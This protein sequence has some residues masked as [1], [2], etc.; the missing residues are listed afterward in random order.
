MPDHTTPSFGHYLLHDPHHRW[1][2]PA[3]VLLSVMVFVLFKMVYPF[4]SFFA[5]SYFYM[6]AAVTHA[7]VD[8]WP[9]G[10]ARF[11]SW[12]HALHHGDQLLISIQY[13]SLTAATW[14]LVCT[15]LYLF[16]P[17]TTVKYILLAW[18]SCNPLYLYLSNIVASD[19]IFTALSILWFTLLL[20]VAFRPAWYQI[21]LQAVVLAAA[22]TLRYNA[23]YYPLLAIPLLWRSRV[24]WGLR[25]AG[26]LLTVLLIG[27]YVQHTRMKNEAVTGVKAF[28][29]FSSWQTTNNAL[30]MYPYIYVD[31]GSFKDTT[32]QRINTMVRDFFEELPPSMTIG[33][34]DG[35]W[36]MLDQRGPLKAYMFNLWNLFPD[37]PMVYPYNRSS[38]PIGTYGRQLIAAHPLAYVRYFLWPNSGVYL[39][40]PLEQLQT[41]NQGRDSVETTGREWFRYKDDQVRGG[42][43]A[44]QGLLMGSYRIVFLLINVLFYLSLLIWWW[45]RKGLLISGIRLQLLWLTGSLF[46]LNTGFSIVAS[47]PV[48]RYQ[49]FPFLLGMIFLLLVAEIVIPYAEK[50]G[51]L[52]ELE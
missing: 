41:Y 4:P 46:V 6:Q 27:G 25:L 42:S 33:P 26:I 14:Y 32:L 30:Y 7:E 34:Q 23:L 39:L 37:K 48:F 10:Y 35:A 31:P 12:V 52:K 13:L 24:S 22:F 5:D 15:V 43:N 11:I 19:A 51:W 45:H 44:V 40:P 49:V 9:I 20:W 17:G 21:V 50:K 36:F 8:M 28:S 18:C 3:G 16:R 29:C 47:P 2:L 1:L 38:V